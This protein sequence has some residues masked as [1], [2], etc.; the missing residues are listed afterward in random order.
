M[1]LP[2]RA[3]VAE[4]DALGNAMDRQGTKASITL[5]QSFAATTRQMKQVS[6][7]IAAARDGKVAPAE[8][9]FAGTAEKQG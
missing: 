3:K 9:F 2:M 4:I 7:G 8:E 6:D 5:E 1:P